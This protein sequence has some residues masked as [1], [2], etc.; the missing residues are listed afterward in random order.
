LPD[1]NF[2]LHLVISISVV[3]MNGLPYGLILGRGKILH[4]GIMGTSLVS[5]YGIF[6]V[7]MNGGGYFLGFIA[8]LGIAILLA[9]V[10]SWLAFRLDSDSFGILTI[11]LHL[12]LLAVVLNW[13]DLTGGA[14]GIAHIPRAPG[15]G[16]P[17]YFALVTSTVALIWG[18]FLWKI[19]RGPL[20]RRLTALAENPS[21]ARSL[22]ISRE[23]VYTTVFVLSAVGS[24]LA[25]LFYPQYI[26]LVHPSDLTFYFMIM[27]IMFIVAGM[28]GG[29][30]GVAL[31]CILLTILKEAIRFLPFPSGALGPLR[32]IV[33]GM[34]L[35]VA[36][37]LRREKLF[38]V[39]RTV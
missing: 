22:G 35:L 34:I 33:F 37:Y 31:S 18:F 24:V 1:M 30:P 9:L 10:F 7:L 5:T 23:K 25:N 3:L 21:H 36:V 32:L 2:F 16:D 29:I 39:P 38:P 8:G 20:G 6:L 27:Y 19:D 14:M 13:I 4:F 28:G 15:L 12:A 26:G 11:A 17:R